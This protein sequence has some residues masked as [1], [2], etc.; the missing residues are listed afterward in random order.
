MEPDPG[1]ADY[2]E[3]KYNA[4]IARVDDLVKRIPTQNEMEAFDTARTLLK[5]LN[6][7]GAHNRVDDFLKRQ[8]FARPKY[9]PKTLAE[10]TQ[11]TYSS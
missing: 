9:E 3:M 2:W 4:A 1:T 5:N 7:Q 8:E 11:R 10:M 6:L